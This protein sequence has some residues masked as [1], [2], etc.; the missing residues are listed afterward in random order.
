MPDEPKTP[1]TRSLS[2]VEIKK[3]LI[4]DAVQHPATSLPST[5]F[6]MSAIWLGLW[7]HKFDGQVE[8]LILLI[9]SGLL[10]AGTFFWRCSIQYNQRYALK[11]K[12]VMALLEQRRSEREEEE[13]KQ[14]RETLQSGFA[15]TSTSTHDGTKALQQLVYVYDRLQAV[16]ERKKPTDPLALAQIPA[17]AEGTYRQGLR[18]LTDALHLM[19]AIR[20]PENE[21]LEREIVEYEKELEVLKNDECEAPRVKMREETIA[22][23]RQRLELV[24]QQALRVDQLLHQSEI[25]EASLHRTHIEIAALKANGM[26]SRVRMVTDTLKN[27]INQ[28]KEVQEEMSRLG[29]S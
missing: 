19:T 4:F 11:T 9:L 13:L 10:A 8:S 7:S 20:S 5:L 26:N 12:E 6:I 25:C 2:E 29:V 3:A 16:V 23:H 27:T 1:H 18:I 14:W 22:S 15:N 21:R 28:A 24:N 17:L